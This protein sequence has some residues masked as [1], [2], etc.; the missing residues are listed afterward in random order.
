MVTTRTT[1]A[2]DLYA[3]GSDAPFELIQGELVRESPAS[4]KS[5]L[6]LGNIHFELKRFVRPRKLGYI[7]VAEAGFLVETNPDT[8]VAPDVAY[9]ARGRM[10]AYIPDR[11]FLPVVP[12][13]IVEVISPADER[14]DIQTKQTLYARISVPLVWWIDPQRETASIHIPGQAI[15]RINRTGQFDGRSVLPGFR[16]AFSDLLEEF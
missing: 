1:T 8:V 14:L 2:A 13:L 10:P 7:S 5:N 9:I 12:D 16:V 4:F 3:M 11:G 6:V 15:Q